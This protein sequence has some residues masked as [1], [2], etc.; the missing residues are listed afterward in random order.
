MS[1]LKHSLFNIDNSV[2]NKDTLETLNTLLI[3]ITD[4]KE[5]LAR[6]IKFFDTYQIIEKKEVYEECEKWINILNLEIENRK[7]A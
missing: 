6:K 1:N 4:Y 7:V 5:D 3:K 2:L